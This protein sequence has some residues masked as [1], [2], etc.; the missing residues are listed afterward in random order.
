[1][2]EPGFFSEALRVRQLLGQAILHQLVE[3]QITARA[4]VIAELTNILTFLV[5]VT[6]LKSAVSTIVGLAVDLSNTMI[7]EHGI[8]RCYIINVD[9][10]Y[11]DET[12]NVD[13]DRQ[14]GRVL[15]CTLLG[16]QKQIRVGKDPICT[17]PVVKA[18]VELKGMFG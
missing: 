14:V 1:M 17:V 18:S 6:S 3:S 13:G 10:E 15:M 11:S 4:E 8:Y 2:V 7:R 12:M 9:Q 5:P 16:L